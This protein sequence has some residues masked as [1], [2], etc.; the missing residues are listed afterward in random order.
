MKITLRYTGPVYLLTGRLQEEIE[1]NENSTV[2]N[3]IEEICCRYGDPL[4]EYVFCISDPE[5]LRP[6]LQI[7]HN[8][9]FLKDLRT[10]IVRDGD[11]IAVFFPVDGG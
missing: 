5:T 1:M 4:R 3:V 8:G 7:I 9:T 6:P 2:F 11:E 10:Q